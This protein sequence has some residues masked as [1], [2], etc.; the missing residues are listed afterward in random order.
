MSSD[1]EGEET[2]AA[3]AAVHSPPENTADELDEDELFSCSE[4]ED[5]GIAASPIDQDG[6]QDNDGK[7]A[8]E[9]ASTQPNPLGAQD[10]GGDQT[11]EKEKIANVACLA[12]N[13]LGTDKDLAKPATEWGYTQL[14]AAMRDAQASFDEGLVDYSDE[15]AIDTFFRHDTCSCKDVATDYILSR[16]LLDKPYASGLLSGNLSTGVLCCNWNQLSR[17]SREGHFALDTVIPLPKGAAEKFVLISAP[18]LESLRRKVELHENV[19]KHCKGF[20]K[21]LARS[22]NVP[23]DDPDSTEAKMCSALLEQTHLARSLKYLPNLPSTL[24][25]R[26]T[27]ACSPLITICSRSIT[28]FPR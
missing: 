21:P 22:L 12:C 13:V 19:E 26:P 25:G 24:P 16:G 4:E 10:S 9:Q 14:A 18:E 23:V 15:K 17:D 2:I 5:D 28:I 20:K 8:P 6:E 3:Q 7:E 1:A 11:I 27:G